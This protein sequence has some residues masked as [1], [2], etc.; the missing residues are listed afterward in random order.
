MIPIMLLISQ[1]PD[2]SDK[3]YLKEV[4]RFSYEDPERY[5]YP[6]I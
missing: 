6:I 5:H 4:P 2:A 3:H 1:G